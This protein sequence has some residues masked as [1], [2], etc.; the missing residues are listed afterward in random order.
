MSTISFATVAAQILSTAGVAN[1]RISSINTNAL[2]GTTLNTY[3]K[4]FNLASN[5]L[6]V[7]YNINYTVVGASN[8]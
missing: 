4:D 6:P 2:D 8:F 7:L 1:V 3:S 5:Q